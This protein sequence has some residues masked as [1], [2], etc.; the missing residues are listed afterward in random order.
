MTV[1]CTLAIGSWPSGLVEG[2]ANI[3]EEVIDRS[4]DGA[5]H[6]DRYGR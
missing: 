2:V 4:L 5:L 1:G 6:N 3:L